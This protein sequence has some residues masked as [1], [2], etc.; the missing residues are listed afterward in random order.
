MQSPGR[1]DPCPCRSGK[2]YKHCCLLKIAQP[3]PLRVES[4]A[5]QLISLLQQA[6]QLHQQGDYPAAE[7]AYKAVLERDSQQPDALHL[8]GLLAHQHGHHAVAISLINQALAQQNLPPTSQAAMHCNRGLAQQANG[9]WGA[10]KRDFMRA[11]ELRPDFPEAHNNLGLLFYQETDYAAACQAFEQGL[12]IQAQASQLHNNLGLARQA[13]HDWAGARQAYLAALRY[14]PHYP[15]AWSNL[16]SLYYLQGE[17]GEAEKALEQARQ[18][19]QTQALSHLELAQL[20]NRIGLNQAAQGQPAMA[21][22]A[23]QQALSVNPNCVDAHINIGLLQYDA[24]QDSLAESAYRQALQRQPD[25]A[26][27]LNNLGNTLARQGRFDEAVTCYQQALQQQPHYAEAYANLG[28]ALRGLG[29][30]DAAIQAYQQAISLKPDYAEA[31]SNLGNALRDQGQFDAAIT[32]YQQAVNAKPDFPLAHSNLLFFLNYHPTW[33]AEKIFAAYQDWEQKHAHRFYSSWPD[34]QSRRAEFLSQ[35]S[36]RLRV[37]YVSPDFRRHAAHHFLEP[38]IEQHDQTAFD[39]FLYADVAQEDAVSERFKQTGSHWRNTCHLSDAALASQIQADQIDILVD[40][41]GHTAGNRLLVFAR[42]PA[43]VQVSSWVGYGYTTGLTAI[44]YFMLSEQAARSEDQAVFAEKLWPLA[45]STA[46]RPSDNMGDVTPLPALEHGYLR[47]GVLS[48]AIR[49]NA[50]LIT[51]W[52]KLLTAIPNAKL[53][54]D[55][56]DFKDPAQQDWLIQQFKAHHIDATR[57]EIGFHSPPW[58]IL[59]SIDITL[60]CFPHNSGT[61]LQESLYMGVP[62]ITYANRPGVGRIG[63]GV[64]AD[65]GLQEWIAYSAEEYIAI[66]QYW[67]VHLPELARL[68]QGL[69]GRMRSVGVS[70]E[71]RYSAQI[72]QAYQTMWQHYLDGGL[73]R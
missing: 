5:N 56:V 50:P 57:L 59:Q 73:S 69:R 25:S 8:L 14:S 6:I 52:A 3:G 44:D 11:I 71:R 32:A 10:A 39:L 18:L 45:F 54:V 4:A 26:L 55:S 42:K 30:V 33:S 68:R 1:N 70:N 53:V 48:R 16:G 7:A 20:W 66:A 29:K 41:A 61:T 47:F 72:E 23:Y 24:G 17:Y 12:A 21:Q 2:K 35:P 37:G 22:Q 38:L 34:W 15:Q 9:D 60:D 62:F 31:Y 65:N 49:I 19:S 43:P 28:L 63:A 27:A 46:F 67:A 64:L 58:P 40:L 36:R 51:V 13:Q